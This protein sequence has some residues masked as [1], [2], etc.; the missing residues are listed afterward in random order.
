MLYKSSKLLYSHKDKIEQILSLKTNEIFD[1]DDKIILYDLT[2]TYFEGRKEGSKP[3][4][5]GRSKEKRSDAKVVALALVVNTIRHRLKQHGVKH[6]WQNIVRIINTQK[7]ATI[8]MKGKNTKPIMYRVCSK[9][10]PESREIYNAL[11]YKPMPY[12]RRK[13]V[14]PKS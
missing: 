14:L 11:G 1:L 10:I 9:P 2:N 3:G 7:T 8:F 5:F 13:F 6:E 4:Q 12:Y